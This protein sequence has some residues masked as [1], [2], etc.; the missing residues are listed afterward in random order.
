[1]VLFYCYKINFKKIYVTYFFLRKNYTLYLKT[2]MNVD[3]NYY[4][5][6]ILLNDLFIITQTQYLIIL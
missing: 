3:I 1:M 6:I 5:Q 2:L 4:Q